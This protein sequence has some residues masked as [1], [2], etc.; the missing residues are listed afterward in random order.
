MTTWLPQ[1]FLLC[2]ISPVVGLESTM[3]LLPH[4]RWPAVWLQPQLKYRNE[5]FN[6]EF[7]FIENNLKYGE[8]TRSFCGTKQLLLVFPQIVQIYFF[9]SQFLNKSIKS[10]FKKKKK[11]KDISFVLPSSDY[12]NQSDKHVSASLGDKL[13]CKDEI[14]C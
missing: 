6:R 13:C 14:K 9:F 2:N 3:Q 5:G 12:Q 7:R 4:S 1:P 11:S 8:K 10:S